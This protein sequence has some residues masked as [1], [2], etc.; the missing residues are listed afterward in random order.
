MLEIHTVGVLAAGLDA[1]LC[2]AAAL[3]ALALY[4]SSEIRGGEVIDHMRAMRAAAWAIMA[5]WFCYLAA[6]NAVPAAGGVLVPIGMLAFAET[7]AALSLFRDLVERAKTSG[8]PPT[9]TDG[10]VPT[11]WP[12]EWPAK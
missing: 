1:C 10:F 3:C 6:F 4:R 12:R 8:R 2:A 5:G 11:D 9:V 7:V